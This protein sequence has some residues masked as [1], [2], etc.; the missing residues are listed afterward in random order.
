MGLCLSARIKAES[1]CH[2]G[3]NSKCVSTDGID[4]SKV[5]SPSVPPTPRSEGEI[6]QSSNL[7][8]FTFADVKMA[9]RNFRPDSV[10]GEGG[11][12]SVFKGW[13][14]EH[15]FAAARPG[16]GMVIAVKRLN[17][18]GF[19][20]HKEWLAEVN[21]LG[22]LYHPHLVKLIGYCLEDEQRLLV[23]E[24]MPRG[25][26][27][28]HLF[29]RGSY[30]QPLLWN[31]RLKV[32]LG[33]AK[34]LAFLH[35]AETQVIYRDF[36]TSNILLDSNYNAKLSDFGLAKDGPTGDKSHVSTRVMGTYG[37]AAP[38]YLATGRLTTKSDVYSFGVVLLEMLSGRR[39]VDKNRPSGEHN[40]VEWAK[41]YL[42]NK[43]K[44]YRIMDNRLVGQYSMDGSQKAAN[45]ASRCL[46]TEAKFRPNMDEVVMELEQ[47]QESKGPG[48][49]DPN[50]GNRP[51]PR[52]RSADDA[53]SGKTAAA[54][55]AYPRPSA[56][57]LYH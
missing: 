26:L 10:L 3:A 42:A 15:S 16:T 14:D 1:P 21:Y 53:R 48:S 18:E 36:K 31:L 17:Q 2:T 51:R 12:G 5:S 23:Y 44:V 57:T 11:F 25:S 30:F 39:A 35:S 28:N 56:S 40:L 4:L 19:Q 47:L 50:L 27:E 38:E 46:S 43:R 20:G 34:G 6:L 8:N 49:A 54:A 55:G 29:R 45:L 7:K 9:T 32:A 13:I 41:P 52:R 33:A 22:Q 37:Y 24:F